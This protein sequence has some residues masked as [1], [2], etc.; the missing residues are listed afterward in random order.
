MYCTC[1]SLWDWLIVLHVLL[2]IVEL[3]DFTVRL[4]VNCGIACFYCTCY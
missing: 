4:D 3:S 2:Y 1:Y